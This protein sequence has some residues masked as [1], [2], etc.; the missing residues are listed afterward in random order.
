MFLVFDCFVVFYFFHSRFC[1]E[2]IVKRLRMD[3]F[4]RKTWILEIAVGGFRYVVCTYF[5]LLV[6]MTTRQIDA[7]S[8][9]GLLAEICRCIACGQLMRGVSLF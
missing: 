7:R 4:C 2:A 6:A 3:V 5:L 9:Q 1:K 8:A